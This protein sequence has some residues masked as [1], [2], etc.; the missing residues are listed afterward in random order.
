MKSTPPGKLL[1]LASLATLLGALAASGRAEVREEFHQTYPLNKQGRV[2]LENVNGNVRV[3]TWDREEI[4]LDATKRAKKQEHL[5]EV[6]IEVDAKPDR[7]RIKTKH[8]DSKTRR[9]KNN[10]TSVEYTLTVPRSC[11]LDGVSTVNGG[12]EIEKV[13]G[14]VKANSVN[15]QVKAVGLSGDVALSTVNGSVKAS[16][17]ELKKDASLKSVNGGVTITL[18][19]E[20]NADVSASTLHG[21]ISSDFSLKTKKHFPVGQNLDG[22]LGEGGPRIEMST[23]NGGIRIDRSKTVALGDR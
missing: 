2:H 13:S 5:D 18:P 6:K 22:K 1:T 10:S 7:I 8:P 14:D 21:G 3:I 19:P 11:H 9:D 12:I 16:F 17:A 23:V 20:A 4:K 15:G